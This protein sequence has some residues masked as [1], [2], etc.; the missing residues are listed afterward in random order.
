MLES[1]RDKPS[2]DL[3]T[4][5]KPNS[6]GLI[7]H[8]TLGS[9]A[10]ARF[11]IKPLNKNH[12]RRSS[13]VGGWGSMLLEI[14]GD[15][16]FA[17]D[18]ARGRTRRIEQ[19]QK[20]IVEVIRQILEADPIEVGVKGKSIECV[21]REI[22]KRAEEKGKIGDV[23]QYLVGAK[24]KVRLGMEIKVVQANKG[25]RR[26]RSDKNARKGDYEIGSS[27]IEIAMGPPDDKHITQVADALEDTELQFWLLTRH[28][29][30]EAWKNEL[31]GTI[32]AK[33]LRR[34]VV[35]SVAAFIGQNLSEMGLFSA[36]EIASEF[37]KM[38]DV[39]NQRW[40]ARVGT[41]GLR[42]VIK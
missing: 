26:S 19:F 8:E 42:I 32:D 36:N 29:R 10:L 7:S 27:T 6:S 23:A 3:A 30:V 37:A 20:A 28:D 35:T 15:D 12:G 39:Y 21:V 31:K 41:P 5:K 14:L 17:Q 34:V 33:D 38:I 2:L 22:L 24:L 9:A 4:H 40:I 16:G 1:L 18:S 11:K 13:D 25:D